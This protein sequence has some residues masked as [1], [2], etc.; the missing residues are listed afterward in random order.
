[1]GVVYR[2]ERTG[3]GERVALKTIRGDTPAMLWALRSEIASLRTIQHPGIVGIVEDGQEDG[4]PWYAME[5][6]EGRMLG[7]FNRDVWAG[8]A[9]AQRARNLATMSTGPSAGLASSGCEARTGEECSDP[10]QDTLRGP[11]VESARRPAAAERLDEVL[12]L[13][14]ALCAPLAHLHARGLVHRDLKPTNVFIRSDGT[15]VLFDFGL[16]SFTRGTIG[17][18]NLP[19]PLI[20]LG[21]EDYVSPEQILGRYVD[22]RGDLYALGCMLYETVTGAPPFA[23][24]TKVAKLSAHIGEPP[25]PPSELVDGVTSELEALILG[26][27]AKAPQERIGYAAD[28]AALLSQFLRVPKVALEAEY[29]YRPEIVG[30]ERL[31]SALSD[32][33]ASLDRQCGGM[34]LLEGES[35]IGKTF[36]VAELARMERLRGRRVITGECVPVATAGAATSEFSAGPL[37]PLRRL[38]RSIADECQRG[39][40]AVAD[41]LLGP[42]AAFLSD[43][44]PAF[45][46][47][48]AGSAAPAK[49]LPAQAAR[50]R[51]LHSLAETVAAFSEESPLILIVDDLQWS[52]ELTLAFLAS[53]SSSYFEARPLLIIGTFRSEDVGPDFERL[54]QGSTAERMR[55]GR[56]DGGTVEAI[57]RDMLGMKAPP[58]TLIGFLGPR[59]EGNPFFVAEYLRLLVAE[60]ILKRSNGRWTLSWPGGMAGDLPD[61]PAPRSLDGIVNRRLS[62][63][64][65]E[66]RAII[67]V[68]AVW[69]RE[70]PVSA[71]AAVLGQDMQ[72]ILAGLREARSRQVVEQLDS[73]RYRFSHDKLRESAYAAGTPERLR[74]LHGRAATHLEQEESNGQEPAA[75]YSALAR[76]YK[77]AGDR[78]KAIEYLDK[79][80]REAIAKSAH[81]EAILFL[82]DVIQQSNQLGE[83]IDRLRMARWCREIGESYQGLGLLEESAVYLRRAA[84]LL[85]RPAPSGRWQL[86]RSLL[87]NVS[88]QLLHRLLPR[89]FLA[90]G[91]TDRDDLA[92]AARVHDRLLQVLYFSGDALAMLHACLS[93]LNFAER[94]GRSADLASAYSNAFAVAGVIPLR[95]LAES[96]RRRAHEANGQQPGSAIECY[97]RM[98][99]G[100]YS[101][102]IAAWDRA[103]DELARGQTLANELGYRRGWEDCCSVDS[104]GAYIRGSFDESL[105]KSEAVYRS[106]LR[107][108]AQTQSWGIIQKSYVLLVH[109][110]LDEA[111]ASLKKVEPL[112][113]ESERGRLEYPWFHAVMARTQLRRGDVA[114]ALASARRACARMTKDPPIYFAWIEAFPALMEVFIHMID[115]ATGESRAGLRREAL[116][117][118]AAMRAQARLFPA[119]RP[120]L[121]LW[122]GR[123][124]HQMGR[125][126]AAARAWQRALASARDLRMPYEEG[127]ALGD[128]AMALPPDHPD[129][130]RLRA[131]A[132]GILRLLGSEHDLDQLNRWNRQPGA[133]VDRSD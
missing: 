86:G 80:G 55:V 6:L 126:G 7:D 115:T 3:S 120:Q 62:G 93:S 58:A 18:E 101:I 38:L 17:R 46:P 44:E 82:Q 97:L 133:G 92:E 34:V 21:T 129:R 50:A 59:T 111:F 91:A 40:P 27:L 35:G 132:E 76:H 12:G 15:P 52:D 123:L 96:Y 33:G 75:R 98:Q 90:T 95:R 36:L 31:L 114:S 4:L 79:A 117:A 130:A 30:R 13:Y 66:A 48:S 43:Y 89:M 14:R 83:P 105:T 100:G 87:A 88:R 10:E 19:A 131:L 104:I 53:L 128:L 37:H 56:L 94:S 22:A 63:L 51:V 110:R 84:A 74:L 47:F 77:V 112:I 99:S 81:K 73:E 107:G 39:G 122:R 45:G 108:D 49:T 70:F 103:S 68:A 28:V 121:H 54:F 127:V 124:A 26:L 5:L 16:V 9:R 29:L 57:V 23:G 78:A 42:R 32:R 106:A 64:S 24:R 25:R 119:A 109:N 69:G 118:G 67:E 11:A 125:H 71:L 60:G 116:R 2:A 85:L 65:A 102:G 113:G 41:R 8:S 1:M 61:L 20:G 72:S